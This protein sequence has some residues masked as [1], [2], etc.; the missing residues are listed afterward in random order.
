MDEKRF[1]DIQKDILLETYK[2][3]ISRSQ[4]KLT[5]ILTFVG[6]VGAGL[7]LFYKAAVGDQ[8]ALYAKL[9]VS[10]FALLLL[11]LSFFISLNFGVTCAKENATLH[12]IREAFGIYD[13]NKPEAFLKKDASNNYWAKINIK[14]Y[15]PDFYQGL[16]VASVVMQVLICIVTF[17]ITNDIGIIT[18]SVLFV[19]LQFLHGK[20]YLRMFKKFS[21]R[22]GLIKQAEEAKH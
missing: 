1:Q 17:C 3:Y 15:I 11:S 9:F 7:Y 18:T 20:L 19:A 16:C 21:K 4:N 6:T 5:C 12:A 2:Q 8:E 10:M 14:N 13:I 22:I